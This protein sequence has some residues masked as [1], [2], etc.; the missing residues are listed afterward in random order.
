MQY[1]TFELDEPSKEV[2]MICTSF[3][4]YKYNRLPMGVSQAPDISQ[5]IMEDLFRNFNEVD[6]YMDNVGVFSQDWNTHRTSLSHI[7]NVLETSG[8]TVNPAKCEWSV[9]ET[10]WLGYWLTPNGLKPWKKK[11][12]A[13]LALKRPETVK[14]LRS[15]IGAV[16]FYRDMLMQRSHILAPLTAL[17]KG[18]GA[19]KWAHECQTSFN[20][21]KALLAKES[22]LWYPDHNNIYCDASDLQL[23]A[24][25]LQEG[26]PVAFYSRKLNSAQCNYTVGE[27]E[28]LSAVETL[29]E[30]RTMLYMATHIST[31]IL[32]IRPLCLSTC[33]HNVFC[34]GV[35]SWMTIQ[36]NS[37]TSTVIATR[38]LMLCLDYLLM[39]SRKH[40]LRPVMTNTTLHKQSHAHARGS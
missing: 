20:T 3:G 8:F 38:L 29:K 33:K 6:V 16:N 22:F 12:S 30:F 21:M 9:M 32:T 11:I 39:R 27:K 17:A 4:N 5:E 15:F 31:S 23:G 10:D 36:S 1:Y 35:Y 25:I 34:N 2:C 28:H 40:M 14:K 37:T 18:K 24:A 19:V 13:I 26:M 7:L